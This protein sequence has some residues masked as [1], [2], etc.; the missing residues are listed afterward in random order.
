MQDPVCGM[1]NCALAPYWSEK[2]GK[3]DLIAYMVLSL[4]RSRSLY[5]CVAHSLIL[6]YYVIQASARGGRLDLH[7]EENKQRVLIRGKAVTIMS[8]Y[9]LV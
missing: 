9:L 2:L 1:A 4:S 8:G 7:V 6:L 3:R 5:M